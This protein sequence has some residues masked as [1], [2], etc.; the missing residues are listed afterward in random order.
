MKIVILAGG[1]GTRLWPLSRSAYPK[2]F[3]RF[4]S[5]YSLLQKT[6]L[7]FLKRFPP[8]DLLF[9]TSEEYVHLV[10]SQLSCIHPS[11]EDAIL[12]E[13][14]RKN[15]MLAITW[16]F[17]V[18]E[19][20]YHL[21]IQ[22]SVLVCPS[23]HLISPEEIFLDKVEEAREIA[24]QGNIVTF[25]IRPNSPETGY[26]YIKASHPQRVSS[27]EAFVEKPDLDTATRYV[28]SGKFLWNTGIF[29]LTRK[30]FWQETC[31]HQSNIGSCEQ[32]SVKQFRQVFETFPEISFDYAI[33]EKTDRTVVMPLEIT[34]SDVGSWDSLYQILDKDDALNV[35]IGNVHAIDTHKSFIIGDKRL[36]STIGLEDTLVI[37]TQDALFIAKRGES[38]RVKALVEMLQNKGAKQVVEHA[39]VHRPWGKYTILEK[40]AQYKIKRISIAPQATVSLQFHQHRSEHWVVVEGTAKV[41]IGE[42]EMLVFESE[43]IYVPKGAIHCLHNPGSSFLEI[44]EVQVGAYLE[45]DD[46]V[47]VETKSREK[48]RV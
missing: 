38:Q 34:W 18:L 23:D 6:A 37:D 25:G 28:L 8:S 31:K 14:A 39:E 24:K 7:R 20:T 27:V 2:Q 21:K 32:A 9:I 35:T 17:K 22:E 1:S 19:E 45:E 44:I 4:G 36:I 47:R 5:E 43:S 30:T 15:T 40:G 13:P 46:I 33:M 10:R 12:L 26:G 41:T 11:L 48:E 29:M 16:A 42:K 3:L